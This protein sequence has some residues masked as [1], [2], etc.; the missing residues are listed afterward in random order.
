MDHYKNQII[1]L[2]RLTTLLCFITTTGCAGI[3][4]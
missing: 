4:T 1:A 3:E 2:I